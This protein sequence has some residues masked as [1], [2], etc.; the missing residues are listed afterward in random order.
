MSDDNRT[1]LAKLI[2]AQLEQDGIG[3]EAFAKRLP[4]KSRRPFYNWLSGTSAPR[5]RN[6]AELEDAL[7]WERG[8]VSRILEAPITERI[9]LAEV[10]DWAQVDEPSTPVARASQLSTDELLVELT[11]RV[12]VLQAENEA[13]KQ[14]VPADEPVAPVRNLFDLAAHNAD[15]PGRMSEHLEEDD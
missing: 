15:H 11:R 8:S 9:T 1:D 10:R 5:N 7:G 2:K 3:P 14:V 6:R 12:G 13:L 4:E